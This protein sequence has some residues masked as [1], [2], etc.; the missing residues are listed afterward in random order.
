MAIT[1]IPTGLGVLRAA[2]RKDAVKLIEAFPRLDWGFQTKENVPER[3]KNG[4]KAIVEDL[5]DRV[6]AGIA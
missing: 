5:I 6:D 4:A 1:H 3:T 2:D